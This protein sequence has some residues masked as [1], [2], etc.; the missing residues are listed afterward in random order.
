[1][2]PDHVG[3]STRYWERMTFKELV[4]VRRMR[5]YDEAQETLQAQ[6][7][8]RKPGIPYRS[9]LRIIDELIRD[10]V[11]E[12]RATGWTGRIG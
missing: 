4:Y 6:Q 11:Q 5:I 7:Y 10:G 8:N 9:V 3:P 2:K 12:P 1:M